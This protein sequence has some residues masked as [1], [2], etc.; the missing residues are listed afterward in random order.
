MMKL[1]ICLVLLALGI[2][3]SLA[4]CPAIENTTR[5]RFTTA[6][7]R[8]AGNVLF[9]AD[10]P[11]DA[12]GDSL[13]QSTSND[14][15]ITE[16]DVYRVDG[17]LL[18][19]LNQYRGLLIVDLA[20]FA[21]IKQVPIYG[22]PRD[23]YLQD[24]RA[25]ALV[26]NATH[27][28]ATGN[29]I[30]YEITSALYSVDVSTA[31]DAA[32]LDAVSL[33]GDLVD[34]RI[35]GDILYAAS[36]EYQW[37]WL[38]DTV[39]KQATEQASWVTAVDLSD[40][41]SLVLAD[42]ETFAGAGD[43]IHVTEQ[44]I[45]VAAADYQNETTDVTYV[46]IED[47]T[48]IMAL[49]GVMTV[50]GRVFDRFKIDA[51][52]GVLRV[53]SNAWYNQSQ[54]YLTTF[55]LADPD[56]P[57]QLGSLHFE[58]AMGQ[59]LFATRFDGDRAYV[60][61]FFVQDPLFVVDLSDPADPQIVGELEVPGWSTHI[62][63]RGDTLIA[64]GVD[65]TNGRQ[66]SLSLF[67]VSDPSSPALTDRV[68]LGADWSWSS[69]YQDFRAFTVTG[70]LA[71]V[72]FSG[73]EE[74][75]YV[76]RLYFV[77][78]TPSGLTE[79]GHVD[80]QGAVM[81]SFEYDT[82]FLAFTQEQLVDV[83]ADDLSAPAVEQELALT[84]YVQDHLPLENTE[85]QVS[86]SWD[87]SEVTVELT[88]G[89][90]LSFAMES[91]Y[92]VL[93]D[94]D[95]VVVVGVK[96][97]DE[98]NDWTQSFQ[99]AA[100]DCTDPNAPVLAGPF[101]TGLEP[102]Y[103]YWAMPIPLTD[104]AFVDAAMDIA[105]PW[106]RYSF[107]DS[108]M[109][110]DGALVLRC[111]AEEYDQVLGDSAPTQGVATAAL[112]DLES[113]ATTGL[114]FENVASIMPVGDKMLVRSAIQANVPNRYEGALV[115]NLIR[116]V[117]PVA[118]TVGRTVNVPGM[119]LRYE[120]DTDL[121]VLR[122]FQWDS[123]WRDEGTY[124]DILRTVEWDGENEITFIDATPLPDGAGSVLA[125]KGRVYVDVYDSTGYNLYV[126]QV[127]PEGLVEIDDGTHVTDAWGQLIDGHDTAAY[128][129]VA[130]GALAR[131][132]TEAAT[133]LTDIV[134]TMGAPMELRFGD[135]TA[136]APLGYHGVLE[137]PL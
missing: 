108:A 17:T 83:N 122:D 21:I 35:V 7:L 33:P 48:G 99:V 60:V 120:P 124:D 89:A 71:L 47:P 135:T 64:L 38:E 74:N 70:T 79:H 34:S 73:Y 10:A 118:G 28:T 128:V 100:V 54:V 111:S 67:D 6:D 136:Y 26:S 132:D 37:Y 22:F 62:E 91:L 78:W 115:A 40:P 4:G 68:N 117:D 110:L 119:V 127:S 36:S 104:L 76:N 80:V 137:I 95:T 107:E 59:Q 105:P 88:S 103:S 82:H 29:T 93:A 90:T 16:P 18:Y 77:G 13:D 63:P 113:W 87:A 129:S 109:I 14:R 9:E 94:E 2:T 27:Y 57:A 65:D 85:A 31:E 98:E 3:L 61:T 81:R 123:N 1:R 53:V 97:S 44:A 121:M 126:V 45:F 112:G 69:A 96:T 92:Q 24:G 49:R 23:L 20:T 32:I 84:T 101:D 116:L 125:R 51:Y 106:W 72:P 114:G 19:V 5:Y 43:V 52:D 131:Y 11:V 130:G 133:T 66:V 42:Q 46:D 134:Q 39:Q 55:D 86:Y 102:Y 50:P 8:Y 25:Y 58:K 12:P 75:S 41:A 56:D 15:E 30:T